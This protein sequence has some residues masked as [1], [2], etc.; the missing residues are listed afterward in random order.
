MLRASAR[1]RLLSTAEVSEMPNRQPLAAGKPL[2]GTASQPTGF[3]QPFEFPT[4]QRRGGRTGDERKNPNPSLDGACGMLPRLN[5]T[6]RLAAM[7]L[8]LIFAGPCLSQAPPSGHGAHHPGQAQKRP[9]APKPASPG[10]AGEMGGM[11]EMMREMGAPPRKEL[12]PSLM[13]LPSNLSPEQ[14]NEFQ[15]KAHERMTAGMRLLSEAVEALSKSNA[16]D[17]FSTQEQAL[18]RA[19]QGLLQFESGL[20]A[21][22]AFAEEKTA[23]SVALG[24][25]RREMD[26]AASRAEEGP[27]T[28][29]G[30][31][32]FH[33]ATI[34][35]LASFAGSMIWIS[36]Q[37]ANR[38]QALLRDLTFANQASP[39]APQAS[40]QAQE[41]GAPPAAADGPSPSAAVAT[42][43][44]AVAATT[45]P[46]GRWSGQLRVARI[47]QETA[48]VR[49][50][51][52]A[53]PAEGDLPFVF[54]P[55]QFLTVS[56]VI[57]GREAKRSY[58][59]ASSPCCRSW[60]EITVK[61]APHGLVSSF[62]HERVK[63]NDL[64]GASG[65]Y[66][67]FS[68]RGAEAPDIVLIAGGVGVTPLMSALRYLT[69]QSWAGE[70]FLIYAC[71]TMADVIYREE[72]EY[73]IRRH[74]NLHVTTVLSD[75]PS[76]GWTGPR[77]YITKDL[78]IQAV[79]NLTAR[80]V[81][82]CG[83]PPMMEAVKAILA[84]LGVPSDQVKTETF[85]GAEPHPSV[86][87]GAP[88]SGMRAA[89]AV[90]TFIRS[91][92]AAPL[93]SDKTILEA[94]EDVGV[95]IDYSCRQG[96]CGVCKTKLVSGQVSMAVEDGL[97]PEDK[98]GQIILACQAKSMADVAVEA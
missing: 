74:P 84:D 77:G 44:K 70:I 7:A 94:S 29:L 42:P 12:Y 52:L 54:Q 40:R 27:Q 25:F 28:L 62:L 9:E 30:L 68:F 98:A 95:N 11:G 2:A 58:S 8:G 16:S 24:W 46:A 37:R 26:L 34:A 78:L 81:H 22:R 41:A 83:P 60:C 43:Y 75:E 71:A 82:L 50:F 13:A 48:D 93:P 32:W 23:G 53:H 5:L 79:P 19:R 35:I 61:A 66:G 15:Q 65:P 76:A 20:A 10:P 92:K 38:A 96:Y 89:A 59:I 45:L 6:L 80:R 88:V 64:I 91:G 4:A 86:V 17:D 72:L 14:R 67:K 85:L 51:R 47:F 69:D 55:G 49:T 97:T 63:V 18:A 21:Q 31:S 56:V 87:A 3:D 57:E 90:C 36:V 33:Y 73:L 39:Y 1:R